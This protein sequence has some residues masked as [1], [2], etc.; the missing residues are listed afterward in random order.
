[1]EWEL[2]YEMLNEF[3]MLKD[4]SAESFEALYRAMLS[5]VTKLNEYDS[6]NNYFSLR[7][8]HYDG[9]LSSGTSV[10]DPESSGTTCVKS[11]LCQVLYADPD[12]ISGCENDSSAVA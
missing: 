12:L 7:R 5:N 11:I 9:P 10:C 1:M 3:E 6:F 8:R 2:E 4:L